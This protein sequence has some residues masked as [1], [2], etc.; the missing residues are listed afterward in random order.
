MATVSLETHVNADPSHVWGQVRDIRWPEALTD[1][2]ASVKP[3]SKTT[4]DC[5]MGDGAKLKETIVAVDDSAR[6]VAYT[7]TESPFG[8]THHNASL[9]ALKDGEGTRLLWTID[10]LPDEVA[11]ALE[12]ALSGEIITMAARLEGSA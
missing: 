11:G 3:T 6:R 7:I 5:T 9:Q 10:V 1:I 4:R 8:T 2:I 12:P